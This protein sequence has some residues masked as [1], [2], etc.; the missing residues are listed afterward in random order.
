MGSHKWFYQQG[1]YCSAH[2]RSLIRPIIIIHEPPSTE[3]GFWD[4]GVLN[5]RDQPT[6]VLQPVAVAVALTRLQQ[7]GF[8]TRLESTGNLPAR[9]LE[10]RRCGRQ[11]LGQCRSCLHVTSTCDDL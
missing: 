9:L 11:H 3:H 2:F 10:S 1:H 5:T 6:V 4:L 7:H 8:E